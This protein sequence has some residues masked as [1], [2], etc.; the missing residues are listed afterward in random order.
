MQKHDTERYPDPPGTPEFSPVDFRETE[1]VAPGWVT[2]SG[3]YTNHNAQNW[4]PQTFLL[5]TS[6]PV[7]SEQGLD[8]D[9]ARRELD[10]AT[11]KELDEYP[12]Q[13]LEEYT[14]QARFWF[15]AVATD[16]PFGQHQDDDTTQP[17]D[18]RER[19]RAEHQRHCREIEQSRS[20]ECDPEPCSLIVLETEMISESP[21][22]VVVY[23]SIDPTIR[24]NARHDWVGDKWVR[25]EV[26]RQEVY[27]GGVVGAKSYTVTGGFTPPIKANGACYVR[28]QKAISTY[29][30]NAGWKRK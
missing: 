30:L 4:A 10:P 22:G 28:G 16:S 19:S 26:T 8:D 11:R 2:Y 5:T 23:A 24:R 27:F 1:P 13:E 17:A 25:L 20:S 14:R 29:R 6:S 18:V 3:T 12:R 7:P 21:T 9:R 15:E